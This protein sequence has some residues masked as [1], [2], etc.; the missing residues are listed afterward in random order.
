FLSMRLAAVNPRIDFNLD[1]LFAVESDSQTL[2]N[3][4]TGTMI[5]P[6]SMWVEE[7][8]EEEEEGQGNKNCQQQLWH[9]H[10][11]EFHQSMWTREDNCSFIPP[12]TSPLSYDEPTANSGEFPMLENPLKMEL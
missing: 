7:Q 4:F 10:C 9:Q 1:A 8:E 11:D 5:M 6:P 12:E 3:N 2:E